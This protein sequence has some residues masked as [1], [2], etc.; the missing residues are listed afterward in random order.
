MIWLNWMICK[1]NSKLRWL[2]I[3]QVKIDVFNLHSHKLF[4]N[5]LMWNLHFFF[6]SYIHIN[7]FLTFWYEII[8]LNFMSHILFFYTL[9]SYTLFQNFS[10]WDIKISNIIFLFFLV[11]SNHPIWPRTWLPRRVNPK[12]GLITM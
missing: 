11:G 6:I 5:F 12:L 4:L 9:Y 7:Y 2:N 8:I 10:M 3:I 1:V